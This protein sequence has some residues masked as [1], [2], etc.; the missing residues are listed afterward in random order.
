MTSTAFLSLMM[1]TFACIG[2]VLA[3]VMGR[4]GHSPYA[5]GPL[6][7]LLAPIA[8]LLALVEVRNE[9]PW[10]T[11]LVASGDPG[12]GPVDVVVGIDGS[13][14]SAAAT[15][16]A[17][18]LL[19]GRVGRL[20]LVAVTDLDDSYAGREERRRLQGEL[21]RQAE[22]VRDRLRE[23][24]GPV[25][26][27]PTVVPELKLMAGRPATVLDTIA[28]EDGY[29]LLVVGARGA[30][31]SRVLLGTVASRLAARASVPV[32]VVGDRA[33]PGR[34]ER[35]LRSVN[36]GRPGTLT[37]AVAGTTP[38]PPSPLPLAPDQPV[39]AGP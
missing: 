19:G 17:L 11:R 26:A 2:F 32:L 5:W 4:L 7:L 27:N 15:T 35:R 12:G 9:R 36:Q 34:G 10:W 14:E 30:G 16:A 1:A 39:R 24:D 18:E 22:G 23:R 25:Q 20:T 6:G 31:L 3:V 33:K 21:E 8:L 28:A 37:E 13:P 29:D 38:S